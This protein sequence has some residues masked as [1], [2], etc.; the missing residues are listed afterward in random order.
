MNRRAQALAFAVCLLVLRWRS[1]RRFKFAYPWAEDGFIFLKEAL[2]DGASSL[3]HSYGGY[4][5]AVPRL[6]VVA[7]LQL[8]LSHFAV[9]IL[10][11]C[12]VIHAAVAAMVAGPA[13]DWLTPDKA[14]RV[15]LAVCL[16]LVAGMWEVSGNLCNLH[17]ILFLY[18]GL[19]AYQ[20]VG[21]PLTWPAVVAAFFAAGSEGGAIVFVPLFAFRTWVKV[22]RFPH[23]KPGR[24]AAVT[25]S[26]LAWGMVVLVFA[27]LPTHS[28]L[29]KPRGWKDVWSMLLA[30]PGIVASRLVLHPLL[31]DQGTTSIYS[32]GP[33]LAVA[34]G[35]PLAAFLVFRLAR[36]SRPNRILLFLVPLAASAMALLICYVRDGAGPYFDGFHTGFENVRYTFVLAP[37]GLVCWFAAL[38]D[39]RRRFVQ[40]AYLIAF[41]GCAI[42]RFVLGPM[43]P[44]RN[45][46]PQ[47]ALLDASRHTGNPAKVV[48]PLNPQ[49]WEF[50]YRAPAPVPRSAPAQ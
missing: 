33:W 30:W 34:L 35:L 10:A 13:Y 1:A 20:D 29:V 45:W 44:E 25:L 46:P 19:L 32:Q 8:P 50:T 40:A 7:F 18:L 38:R 6:A 39:E 21:L 16:C 43:G 17:S 5:H 24:D 3:T 48:V 11:T 36:A 4:F 22:R 37:F 15:G 23:A 49:G 12:L 42:H 47:A 31:G 9:L 28:Q 27:W 26:I 14:L 2:R 41:V